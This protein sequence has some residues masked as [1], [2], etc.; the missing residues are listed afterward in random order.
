MQPRIGKMT[1]ASLTLLSFFLAPA[2]PPRAGASGNQNGAD[3]LVTISGRMQ[4]GSLIYRLN[5]K[6]IEDTRENSLITNLSEVIRSR[7][8][9]IPALIIIDVRAPLTEVGKIETALDKVDL[10]YSRKLF[11]TD[12]RDGTMNEIH[13]DQ[14]PVPLP[15][16]Y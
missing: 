11:V 13:W 10:T 9:H 1:A 3:R 2:V 4:N 5:G 7:G 6:Q 15:R 14:T 16:T 8:N 12:F